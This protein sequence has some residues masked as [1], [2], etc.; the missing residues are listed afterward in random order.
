MK[1]LLASDDCQHASDAHH[2]QRSLQMPPC[3]RPRHPHGILESQGFNNAAGKPIR[4]LSNH[5]V[6]VA[7]VLNR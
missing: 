6:E 1:F 5:L 3:G 7:I 2:G 4:G